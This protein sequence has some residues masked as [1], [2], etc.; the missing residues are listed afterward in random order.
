MAPKSAPKAS[1][2]KNEKSLAKTAQ[3]PKNE[4]KGSAKA[5][6]PKPAQAPKNEKKGSAKAPAP[7][8]AAKD[9]KQR[10]NVANRNGVYVKNWGQGSVGDAKAIFK[11]AGNVVDVRVRRGRYAIVFFDNAVAVKKAIDLFNEKEVMGNVVTV[12]PAKTSPKPDPHENSSVVFVSPIFRTSTTNK[13]IY[14][15][16]SSFKV[17]RLRTYRKNHAYIYLDSP[18]AALRAV[19]DKNGV[20]FRGKKLRVALSTRSLEKEKARAG[21]ARLLMDAHS[22][23]KERSHKK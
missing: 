1:A 17:L 12:V 4:K 2:A 22:F 11:S 18:A 6:A 15:L 10:I 9:T 19:K 13:Q 14:E 20:E 7:K 5:P 16:F 23:K 21:R 8:P 3:A